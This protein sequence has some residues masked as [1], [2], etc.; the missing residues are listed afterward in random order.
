M[1]IIGKHFH[2]FRRICACNVCTNSVVVFR[3]KLPHSL[4]FCS[5]N[6][7][8]CGYFPLSKGSLKKKDKISSFTIGST[9]C[10]FRLRYKQMN[11]FTAKA[12]YLTL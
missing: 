5:H 7:Q 1:Y 10:P 12:H 4:V 8:Q 11:T 6:L 3:V 9:Q 2:F